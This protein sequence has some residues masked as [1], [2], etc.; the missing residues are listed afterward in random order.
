MVKKPSSMTCPPRCSRR[1]TS[2]AHRAAAARSRRPYRLVALPGLAIVDRQDGRRVPARSWRH[3]ASVQRTRSH[4]CGDRAAR[5]VRRSALQDGHDLAGQASAR[6]RARGRAE[7][8]RVDGRDPLPDRGR[9]GVRRPAPGVHPAVRHA[10]GL[11]PG[12]RDQSPAAERRGRIDRARP[13]LLGGRAGTAARRR[14]RQRRRGRAR[15]LFRPPADPRGR[16][17]RGRHA[18]RLVGRRR[19]HLRHADARPGRDALPRQVPH[20]CRGAL[21]V[22]LDP[23][24]LLPGADR[25]PGRRHAA[26]DGPPPQPARATST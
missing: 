6:F 26:Q 24:G 2:L 11:D 8:G 18:R 12:R 9:P 15:L 13:V 4:R 20:R 10:R 25:R 1:T 3:H 7:R 14:H 21:L 17:D 5:R 22:P 23:A 16:A 19:G